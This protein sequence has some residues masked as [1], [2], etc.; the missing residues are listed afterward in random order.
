MGNVLREPLVLP[1][2]VMIV[3]VAELPAEMRRQIGENEDDGE[4]FALTRPLAREPSKLIDA[5]AAALIEQFRTPRTVVQAVLTYSRSHGADPERTLEDS[6]PLLGQLLGSGLLVPEGSA[7]A[8]PIAASWPVGAMVGPYRIV[9]ALQ[10]LDDSEI[11]QARADD[12]G[13]VALKVARAEH[14][15]PMRRRLDGEEAALRRLAGSVAPPVLGAGT[16]EDRPYLAMGWAAG[17]DAVTVAAELRRDDDRAGLLALQAEIARTYAELHRRGV[18]HGDIH[19]GNLIVGRDGGVTLIDF[20]LAQL[21]GG[22]A[23]PQLR[24]GVGFF[25]EPEH[26]RELLERQ[27]PRPPTASGE[28]FA[29]AALLYLLATGEPYMEFTLQQ[30]E[31]FRQIADAKP[32]PFAERGTAPWPALEEILRRALSADP[33]AR[34]PGMDALAD[35][36]AAISVPPSASPARWDRKADALLGDMLDHLAL[37]GGL[38]RDG[39]AEG[40]RCSVNFGA[41]GIAYALHRLACRRDDPRLLAASDAWVLKAERDAVAERAFYDPAMD[42]TQATIGTVSFYHTRPGLHLVQAL[43]ATSTGETEIRQ[44]STD[45]FLAAIEA[46]C[47]ER[48]LCLGRTGTVLGCTI[49]M[50]SLPDG[51]AARVAARTV[52]ERNLATLWGEADALEPMRDGRQWPNL[53]IAHGWAGLL[54]A[55]LR[56]HELTG[57]PLPGTARARLEQLR[58]AARPTGRGATWPWRQG[59]DDGY[60]ASMP[61]WC[62]GAAGMVHLATLAHRLTGDSALLEMGQSAAWQAW[63]GGEGPVD[64]CCGFAGRAYA[65]LEQHR[66]TGD[67]A[68]LGRARR[69][70]ER[71]IEVAPQLRS[72]DHPRHSLYKGELGLALLIADLDRPDLATMP[73]FGPEH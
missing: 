66:S 22:D 44:A 25:M 61:G 48:D 6:L 11:F 73:L 16:I 19:P 50:D 64:L 41:A 4:S 7:A 31:M 58:E 42:M 36:L 27:P 18:L 2:D 67:P 3:A 12:G 20:G 28:Q 72:A 49:L 38:F 53:G 45:A 1:D 23:D 71:A 29:I 33:V 56:L 51:D 70:A 68:W 54:Y 62:N 35:A 21:E 60:E 5:S 39:V 47:R 30:E 57:A 10:V 24:G 14:A 63:E 17:S 9:R 32:L 55:T 59:P 52:A 8:R 65:L 15:A 43:I 46:P 69:L 40:P 13:F 37:D 26:A 34:Y